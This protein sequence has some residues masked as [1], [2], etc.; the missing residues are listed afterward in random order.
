M[1]IEDSIITVFEESAPGA[2]DCGADGEIV[3]L[4]LNV[5][6]RQRQ[7]LIG[8][9][10]EPARLTDMVPLARAVSAKITQSVADIVELNGAR[11]PC[12]KG[13]SACCN[14][15]VP[16]AIPEVFRLRQ[17]VLTMPPVRQQLLELH[18]LTATQRILKNPPPKSFDRAGQ[19]RMAESPGELLSIASRWYAEFEL[20]CP[21]LYRGVCT[22]YEERPMACREYSVT[23]CSQACSEG[24]SE[25]QGVYMPARMSE[26]L[27]QLAADL[28]ETHVEAVIMPLALIWA[29][30]NAEREARTWPAPMMV[31]RFV[32]IV[33]RALPE[34]SVQIDASC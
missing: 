29:D 3:K 20:R 25:P 34:S 22:I 2:G 21:F 12:C 1:I 24:A 8:V 31:E 5:F 6:G 16:L 10:N 28:E 26:V 7:L 15:L 27:G 18:C 4:T 13:C 17:E 23:G 9:R 32:E 11:I 33:A 30:D 14:Y 19:P